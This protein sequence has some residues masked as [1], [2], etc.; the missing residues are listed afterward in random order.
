MKKL[1]VC[2]AAVLV[3]NVALAQTK[4]RIEKQADMPRFTYAVK[5]DL[6]K[7]VRD[8]KTF[9]PLAAQI[10]RDTEGVL[11]KYDIADKAM[12]A[13]LL[14]VLL[15]LAI[16][17]GQ[18]DLALKHIEALRAVQE[19]PADKLLTGM[20][21]RAIVESRQALGNAA[22]PKTFQQEVGKRLARSL[23]A[24]PFA[25][26]SNDIKQAKARAERL[27]E[28][29][30]LGNV[31]N[32]LQPMADKSG[33]LS[34]EFAPGMVAARY[35]LL[36]TLPLKQT[37]ID[38]YSAYLQA[39]AVE[40]PDMWAAR[41]VSLSADERGLN[42]VV[43]AVWDSGVD[44]SVFAKQVLRDASGKALLMAFDKYSNPSST[45]L[46]ALSTSAQ[47]N[48]PRLIARSKGLS[49]MQSNIDSPEASEVK[50]LLSTLK[51]QDFKPVI[52][53]LNLIGN[54]SHGTHV[55][56]I[57]LQGNPLARLLIARLEFGHTLQ[58]DPCP[59]HEQAQKDAKATAAYID[60]FRKNQARVVNMSW[61]GS[62]RA[63]EDELEKCG[64]GKTPEERQATA[65]SYFSIMRDA[66]R[67]GFASAPDILFVTAAGNSNQNASF[68]E[69]AP[70]DIV[71]PNL[72][73]VGAVD[74]AGDEASF[75]S[76]GPTVKVHANGY[77]VDSY[78]PGGQRVAFS[79]TS[80]AAPQVAN[81]AGKMLAVNPK[82]RPQDVIAIV[83]ATAEKSTD[84]R[85]TLIHPAKALAAARSR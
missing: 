9:A 64:I 43:V 14:G 37:L 30:I 20:L 45:E 69:D 19:K 78:L 39:N 25:V 29:L 66:L 10:R 21:A 84:G 62:V 7:W 46:E 75:T 58:P 32:V 6:E 8:E 5:G 83:V 59:S 31:Q 51:P 35:G 38:T 34:S 70:A 73:T 71:L 65:R 63:I 57:A 48:L 50:Q 4:A 15:P 1:L 42:P 22:D 74:K 61:G 76:Y 17:D 18:H 24:L 55:A 40:K 3:V 81:L 41:D 77:Q 26:I 56:G 49:D 72:I 53:E 54:Y 27:G 44:S 79:G 23:Q 28:G 33:E 11:G 2:W 13:Q 16:L 67:Q 60:F 85:R 68:A 12:Q 80:M 36:V 47:A 52:E 82:L